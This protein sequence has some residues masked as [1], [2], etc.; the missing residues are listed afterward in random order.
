MVALAVHLG[1]DVP[2]LPDYGFDVDD[3]NSKEGEI[4]HIS[5][6]HPS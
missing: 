5:P 4:E 3:V 2:I 6:Y 1:D